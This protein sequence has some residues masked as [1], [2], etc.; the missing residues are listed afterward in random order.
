M[1]VF[2]IAH[3]W[4]LHSVRWRRIQVHHRD[5]NDFAA[6]T[7]PPCRRRQEA[8]LGCGE[9]ADVRVWTFDVNA[10]ADIK[11]FVDKVSIPE[12]E[13]GDANSGMQ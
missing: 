5:A 9:E 7:G 8:G 12:K 1:E 13:A 11:Y 6:E 2:A 3:V 10:L 4:Q